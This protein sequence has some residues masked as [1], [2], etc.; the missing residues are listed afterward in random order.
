M[1][2]SRIDRDTQRDPVLENKQINKLK[3]VKISVSVV[4]TRNAGRVT[5]WCVCPNSSRE[6]ALEGLRG[7]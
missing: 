2:L 3:K 5:I 7:M 1:D 6:M 4:C